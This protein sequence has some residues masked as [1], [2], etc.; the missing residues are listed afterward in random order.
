MMQSISSAVNLAASK[1]FFAASVAISEA[2]TPSGAI[3]R[4]LIPVRS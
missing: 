2:F 4:S 1:A 3:R